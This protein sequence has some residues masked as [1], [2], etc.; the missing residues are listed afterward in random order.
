MG[1]AEKTALARDI[2]KGCKVIEQNPLKIVLKTL[3]DA[4]EEATVRRIREL[5]QN[6]NEFNIVSVVRGNRGHIKVCFKSKHDSHEFLKFGTID[7]N[8]LKRLIQS[9]NSVLV[10]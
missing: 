9:E 8:D 6:C 7:D 4:N 3:N 10:N 5:I 2:L 1:V